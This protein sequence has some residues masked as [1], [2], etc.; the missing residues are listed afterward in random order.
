[1]RDEVLLLLL[2]VLCS[3][4]QQDWRA[5]ALTGSTVLDAVLSSCGCYCEM[6]CWR[7]CV[8]SNVV[9]RGR[10]SSIG[11]D[12]SSTTATVHVHEGIHNVELDAT[13]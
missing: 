3:N 4:I 9:T 11:R 13:P 1:M 6:N 2:Y 8:L 7:C 12:G 5:V 10:S